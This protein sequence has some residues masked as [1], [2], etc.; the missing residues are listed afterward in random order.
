MKNRVKFSKLTKILTAGVLIIFL[1]GFFTNLPEKELVFYSIIVGGAVLSGLYYCPISV[2]ADDSQIVLNR[3][4]SKSKKF[5]YDDIVRIETCYPSAGGIR[6]CGSGGFFGYWG[7]FH[8]IMYGNYFGYYGSR[9]C[10]FF[11]ELTDGRKY[12]IGC[13]NQVEFVDFVKSQISKC[14]EKD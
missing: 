6:L 10:C 3:L 14:H 4:M 1:V 7:H 8:D 12:I 13:E 5:L 11:M 9:D 2:E